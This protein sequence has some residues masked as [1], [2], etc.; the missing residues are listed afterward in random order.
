MK[1]PRKKWRKPRC[2]T[3]PKKPV[4]AKISWL[5]WKKLWLKSAGL[6]RL[7]AFF[8]KLNFESAKQKSFLIWSSTRKEKIT[9]GWWL[10]PMAKE[11]PAIGSAGRRM[12]KTTNIV[13]KITNLFAKNGFLCMVCRV[14]RRKQT[15]ELG[16]MRRRVAKATQIRRNCILIVPSYPRNLTRS[17][18]RLGSPLAPTTQL[19]DL[20]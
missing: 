20:S 8:R 9:F 6:Q 14:Y 4:W 7:S 3:R 18:T 13:K 17:L 10:L 12:I 19:Q 5:W 2:G 16:R 11:N 15:N 1:R